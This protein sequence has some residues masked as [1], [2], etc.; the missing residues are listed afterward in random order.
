MVGKSQQRGMEAPEHIAFIVKKQTAMKAVFRAPSSFY[1]LSDH[2]LAS[3]AT[4]GRLVLP[5]RSSQ[6]NHPQVCPEA[7]QP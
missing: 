7:Q 2:S 5:S 3:R 1:A 6:E 4:H